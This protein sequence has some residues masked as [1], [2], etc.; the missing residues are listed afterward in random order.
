MGKIPIVILHKSDSFYLNYCIASIKKYNPGG[1]IFL[2]CEGTKENFDLVDKL[3]IS[4]FNRYSGKLRKIYVHKNTSNPLIELFCIERWLILKDFMEKRKFKRIFTMDSDVLLFEDINK[5]SK[6]YSRFDV[7]LA[8][9]ASAGLTFIN[10]KKVLDKYCEIV[11]D[12]Y[13]HKVGKVEYESNNTITDMSFWKELK[14]RE[15]LNIG[16]LTDALAGAVYDA[17]LLI[18]QNG[19][20]MDNGMKRIL[21]KDSLPYGETKGSTIRLKCLHCQGPTKFYMK[22]F[23]KGRLTLINKLNV[24]LMMTFRD[25]L[26]P[27]MPVG[28]RDFFKKLLKRLKF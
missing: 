8:K 11:L 3:P 7:I 18:E 21:F 28:L 27:L 16:E 25:R 4:N 13:R 19:I 2:L 26:S 23:S 22:H 17:G 6:N 15:V 1:K 5:D 20:M 9:G 24:K 10:N 12:F 14:R